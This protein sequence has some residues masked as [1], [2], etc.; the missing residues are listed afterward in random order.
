MTGRR[1]SR[2]PSARLGRRNHRPV[3]AV[4]VR[5]PAPKPTEADDPGDPPADWLDRERQEEAERKAIRAWWVS[6]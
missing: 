1:G 4:V 6:D 5:D 3:P 2:F